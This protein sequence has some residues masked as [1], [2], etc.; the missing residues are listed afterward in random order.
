MNVVISLIW[1]A[2]LIAYTLQQQFETVLIVELWR[3]GARTPGHDN[4]KEAYVSQ[5]GTGQLTPNGMRQHFNLGYALRKRYPALF[6]DPPSF[7][8]LKIYSTD[9]DRTI[10]S[11]QSHMAGLYATVAA[12]VVTGDPLNTKVKEPPFSGTAFDF[13]FKGSTNAINGGLRPIPIHVKDLKTDRIFMKE[14]ESVCPG[15]EKK[16]KDQFQ[17]HSEALYPEVEKLGKILDEK[18]FKCDTIFGSLC[19]NHAGTKGAWSLNTTGFFGDMAKCTYYHD[20]KPYANLDMLTLD[21]VSDMFN[22]FYIANKYGNDDLTKAYNT[23]MFRFIVTELEAKKTGLET[24][25]DKGLKY[26]GLSAHETNVFPAM[27]AFNLI[28]LECALKRVQ[29]TPQANCMDGPP[30]ASNII[31][32]LNKKSTDGTFYVKGVYN[33]VAFNLCPGKDESLNCKF[34][35]FKEMMNSKMHTAEGMNAVCAVPPTATSDSTWIWVAVVTAS[36]VLVAALVYFF[37]LRKPSYS[38]E[39]REGSNS[40][41][42]KFDVL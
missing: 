34:S 5:L 11:A 36:V 3:H 24:N 18:G 13:D 26:I 12:P 4:L 14:E 40:I 28:S 19:V 16:K 32:E 27:M 6:L 9:F 8:E 33:G 38:P 15:I 10:T 21:K 25:K 35:D 7:K 29:G 22:L 42:D 1:L 23:E 31:F 30:F 17:K 41:V 20:G 39:P 37:F 2:H